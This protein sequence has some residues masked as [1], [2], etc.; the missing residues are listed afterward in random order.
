MWKMIWP[1]LL[2]VCSG[3]CYNICTKS[4]P[5]EINAFGA[6]TVTYLVSAVLAACAFM[7]SL[8]GAAPGSEF[9]KLNW[10]SFVLGMALVGLEAGYIFLYRAGW[11]ISSGSITANICIA[12]ML[13]MIG[14]LVFREHVSLKQVAGLFVCALGI[15]L[16]NH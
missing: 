7:F 6:L 3:C 9:A 16:I 11:K 8:K 13:F 2:I 14:V 12:C 10:A 1:M 5:G 15:Y 4:V